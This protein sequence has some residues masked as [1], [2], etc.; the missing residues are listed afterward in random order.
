MINSIK[1]S[2]DK[3]SCDK[4]LFSYA[5]EFLGDQEIISYIFFEKELYKKIFSDFVGCGVYDELIKFVVSIGNH[6]RKKLLATNLIWFLSYQSDEYLLKYV[7]YFD[8]FFDDLECIKMFGSF[9]VRKNNSNHSLVNKIFSRS[10]SVE[11]IQ[12]YKILV[13]QSL[14]G[15]KFSCL[16][17]LQ[18]VKYPGYEKDFEGIILRLIYQDEFYD[19]IVSYIQFFNSSVSVKVNEVWCR[20]R[21]D[22]VDKM[23]LRELKNF[24]SENKIG[25]KFISSYKHSVAYQKIYKNNSL[26]LSWYLVKDYSVIEYF[27]KMKEIREE[28]I[29][30]KSLIET[31]PEIRY[32]RYEYKDINRLINEVIG[33]YQ[34]EVLSENVEKEILESYG[35]GDHGNVKRKL[36]LYRNKDILAASDFSLE[37]LNWSVRDVNFGMVN[38]LVRFN[39]NI[40]SEGYSKIYKELLFE[41]VKIL[42]DEDSYRTCIFNMLLNSDHLIG[43]VE[44]FCNGLIC[45]TVKNK[46]SCFLELLLRFLKSEKIKFEISNLHFVLAIVSK[47][48]KMVK[49]LMSY[50]GVEFDSKLIVDLRELAKIN[51]NEFYEKFIESCKV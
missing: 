21:G 19:K 5:N 29:R 14:I 9:I 44:E 49:I 42:D 30:L 28:F 7:Y 48:M 50:C 1:E 11:L 26:L 35:S 39:N 43:K 4:D 12:F 16:S 31:L 13:E 51:G 3:L 10:I 15:S 6:D 45:E 36:N 34:E 38:Y 41:I 2:I 27:S 24:V 46:N 23:S 32:R 8:Y 22:S 18:N 33:D 40:V 37:V 20:L 47:D 17:D 25:V